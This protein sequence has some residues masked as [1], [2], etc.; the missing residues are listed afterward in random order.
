MNRLINEKDS[1]YFI[2]ALLVVSF[3]LI[4]LA[5]FLIKQKVTPTLVT[6]CCCLMFFSC[7]ICI[8]K[9]RCFRPHMYWGHQPQALTLP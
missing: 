4:Q 1:Q 8:G 3:G 9:Y 7:T 5:M 6:T 2:M